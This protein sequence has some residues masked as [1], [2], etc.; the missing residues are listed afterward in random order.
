MA[1]NVPAPAPS[2]SNEGSASSAKGNEGALSSFDRVS[3]I[4]Y[5]YRPP[6][7]KVSSPSS[8]STSPS[9]PSQPPRLILV[10]GWMDA[11]EPHLAKYTTKLQA[12]YPDAAILLVRSFAYHF[13]GFLGGGGGPRR[14]AAE[15]EPAVALVRSI[16]AAASS[17][18]STSTASRGPRSSS[19]PLRARQ[20]EMLVHVFS[21]GG[22]TM[23]RLLYEAHPL[24]PHVTIFDSAPGRFSRQ[25]SVRAFTLAAV[26]SGTDSSFLARLLWRVAIQCFCAAYWIFHNVVPWSRPG[27]LERTWAAHNDRSVNRSEVRRAYVYSEEDALVAPRD[28]EEHAAGARAGGFEVVRLA[29]FVGTAHVAHVRGDEERYW[30]VVREAWEGHGVGE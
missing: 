27:A 8:P 21:N 11:R 30:G 16:M 2:I 29:R 19:S 17:D 3:K 1:A 18:R 15:M 14:L 5:L 9:S 23:L 6:P 24:P 26:S 7:S 13:F 4:V 25:S 20:P 10:G 22:S 28:V 12:L